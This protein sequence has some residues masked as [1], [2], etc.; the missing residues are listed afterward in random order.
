MTLSYP[1]GRATVHGAPP[2]APDPVRPGSVLGLAG[3]WRTALLPGQ[4][5]LRAPWLARAP[6]GSGLPVVDLPGW[7]APESSLTPLRTYLRARGHDANG[8]GM[9]V[10]TGDPERD[11]QLLVDRLAAHHAATGQRTALVGWSLGGLVAREAA[12]L[13]PHLVRR[14]ITFGTPVVGGPTFTLGA[15]AWGPVEGARISS[16]LT[17]LDRDDPIQV[18]ITA[19]FT[20]RD[21]VVSWPAC[22]DRSSPRVEHVE[23]RTTHAGLTLDPHVWWVVATRLA[24]AG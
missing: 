5:L 7:K 24:E 2:D 14:V 23:V 3:E 19:I 20:R 8:W 6:R 18:P 4:L 9:G 22:L 21:R 10:N 13:A 1:A 15:S 16:M 12:R 17:D 11:S